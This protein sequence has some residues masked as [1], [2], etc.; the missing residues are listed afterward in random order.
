VNEK[1]ADESGMLYNHV[2]QLHG[3]KPGTEHELTIESKNKFGWSR[4][5]VSQFSTLPDGNLSRDKL[6]T[7]FDS[8]DGI[9]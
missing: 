4:P 3:L 8:L 7:R 2:H 1:D 6:K 5:L 9:S